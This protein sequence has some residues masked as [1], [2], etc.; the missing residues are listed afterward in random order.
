MLYAY[1]VDIAMDGIIFMLSSASSKLPRFNQHFEALSILNKYII[2][3]ETL[4]E[5]PHKM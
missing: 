4:N 5:L 1:N 2:L 3:R